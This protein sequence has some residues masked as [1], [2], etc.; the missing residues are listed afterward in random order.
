MLVPGT[1]IF[2]LTKCD[3]LL[4]NYPSLGIMVLYR[5]QLAAR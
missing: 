2:Q 4:A 5:R 1:K 3:F